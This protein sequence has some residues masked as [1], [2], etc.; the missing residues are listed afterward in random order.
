MLKYLQVKCH[1]VYN[2]GEGVGK[3][4]EKGECANTANY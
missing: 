4:R 2:I 1:H 3:E